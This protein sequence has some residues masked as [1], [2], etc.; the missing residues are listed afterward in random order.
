MVKAANALVLALILKFHASCIGLANADV[1]GVGPNEV[2]FLHQAHEYP[3]HPQEGAPL[4][5]AKVGVAHA[6]RGDSPLVGVNRSSPAVQTPPEDLMASLESHSPPE[7]ASS[8]PESSFARPSDCA[9]GECHPLAAAKSVSQTTLGE[10]RGIW[11]HI[12]LVAVDIDGTVILGK[13][14]QEISRDSFDP[15]NVLFSATFPPPPGTAIPPCGDSTEAL[16]K[17]SRT[18]G[19]EG[20]PEGFAAA[21]KAALK[22]YSEGYKAVLSSYPSLA[23]G[24]PL[25]EAEM[26][27]LL[28]E[29]DAYERR[30]ASTENTRKILKG[31]H[32]R[33]IDRFANSAESLLQVHRPAAPE[34]ILQLMAKGIPV[35]FISLAWS[36]RLVF[37]ALR[38]I[39][40]NALRKA[41]PATAISAP[42][43]YVAFADATDLLAQQSVPKDLAASTMAMLAAEGDDLLPD[44]PLLA[45]DAN[46]LQFDADG[47]STGELI[48]RVVAFSDKRRA[49][50]E[51]RA[52]AF[53]TRKELQQ[54]RS[55]H[56]RTAPADGDGETGSANVPLNPKEATPQLTVFI[57]DSDGDMAGFLS[58][59]IPIS[60]GV[61]SIKA[62]SVQF[63]PLK[64]L[65]RCLEKGGHPEAPSEA[66]VGVPSSTTLHLLGEC[67]ALKT[68]KAGRSGKPKVIFEAE[69]WQEIYALFFGKWPSEESLIES[70]PS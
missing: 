43:N 52:W 29:L 45:V 18:L 19:R 66:P 22:A 26:H 64:Q 56:H 50:L 6:G 37:Q 27:Q 15:H 30:M 54:R 3:S 39:L 25:Q 28:D 69:S 13:L 42:F 1:V 49:L 4:W 5:T 61:L 57:G 38:R 63:L 7:G 68:E 67:A 47:V 48:Q 35:A 51:R 59:D 46:E 36:R 33:D 55:A 62:D 24:L 10:L 23:A 14:P 21:E 17:A 65:L 34:T 20:D 12:L 11:P 58:A 41:A 32:F 53:I 40:R 44:M 9:K 16:L 60:L 31:L 2:A 70:P 8:L